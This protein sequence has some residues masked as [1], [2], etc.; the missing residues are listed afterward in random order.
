MVVGCTS[1]ERAMS[2]KLSPC[3]HFIL[4]GR[5]ASPDTPPTWPK[6][7]KRQQVSHAPGDHVVGAGGVAA[8][9]EAADSLA[10]FIEA[11][12]AAEDINSADTLADHWIC[13]IERLERRLIEAGADMTFIRLVAYRQHQRAKVLARSA[14]LS[15][16][17][18]YD[19]LLDAVMGR[20]PSGQ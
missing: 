15:V 5:F 18:D 13:F 9:T 19:L 11:E 8:Y 2:A 12:A 17:D 6:S 10:I 7:V 16:T 1:Y 14:R 20:A 3:A 4:S